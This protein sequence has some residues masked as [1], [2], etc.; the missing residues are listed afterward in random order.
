MLT[1]ALD[2]CESLDRIEVAYARTSVTVTVYATSNRN[3]CTGLRFAR[4]VD[5][6]LR[7]GLGGRQVVDGARG[8]R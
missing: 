8:K 7:E 3:A 1:Y 6:P 4:S 2:S 5:V